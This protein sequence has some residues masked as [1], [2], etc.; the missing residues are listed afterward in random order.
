MKTIV[1]KMAQEAT[2]I[3]LNGDAYQVMS[4]DF[5]ES[6]FSDAENEMGIY[7]FDEET[8]DETFIA[9]SEID[10]KRDTFYKL[11]VMDAE[12]YIN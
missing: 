12:E 3:I 7:A 5:D 4:C 2:V 10:L 9:Y 6:K 11:V 1:Q 8:Q